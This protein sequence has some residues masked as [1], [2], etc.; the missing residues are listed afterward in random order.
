MAVFAYQG[1][2]ASGKSVKGVRDADSPRALRLALRREGVLVTEVLQDAVARKRKS[3]DV[4]FAQLFRRISASDI[5]LTT[6]QLAT[7]LA[8]GIPLVEAL[9]AM[10]EQ[11]EHPD[12]KN[13]FTQTRDKVNEGSSLADAMRNHPKV[14]TGLYVNMVAAGEASGTLETVLARLADFLDA[15]AKLKSEVSG[16]LA[17]P[18]FMI[19]L[20]AAVITLMMT[21]VVPK[22]TRIFEDFDQALPI[23]TRL[24]ILISDLMAN[25]WYL[26]FML[27]AGCVYAF[28][29]WL[30]TEEGRKRF[31]IWVLKL[32]LFGDLFL[33]VAVTRF[34][35]TLATL[36]RSGVPVLA[37]MDITRN[38]IGNTELMRIV[39][40][41]RDE[42]REG[43]SIAKPLKDSGQFPPI[44]TH[45]IAIGERSGQL[46]EMLE[47]V[48]NAYDQQV[49]SRVRAVTSLL[50]PLMIVV[51]GGIIGFIAFSILMPLLQ[52]NQFVR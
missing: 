5:A 48:A 20:S 3:R 31:D 24:L 18:G 13:A 23:Y 16:A 44:V 49:E 26:L 6:R 39:D 27:F 37:A 34:A 9:S 1:I 50:E 45:M 32:P 35:R 47:H 11:L 22:V 17:Y 28:R 2:N 43:E 7:L 41:A 33:K 25:Y 38:V 12:L 42:V 8:S 4:D 21:V 51:L 14:F 40:L 30:N 29:R 36:L 15:Q 46:E 52:I 10:I 19:I